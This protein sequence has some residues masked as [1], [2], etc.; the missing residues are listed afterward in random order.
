MPR[1]TEMPSPEQ[2]AES[3]RQ[4]QAEW[5]ESQRIKRTCAGHEQLVH[6]LPP[7]VLRR[8]RLASVRPVMSNT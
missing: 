6:W 5:S 8:V 4:I 3:C 1:I 2:I 7:G